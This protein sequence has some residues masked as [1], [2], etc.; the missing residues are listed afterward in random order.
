M[1]NTHNV[2]ELL[3]NLISDRLNFN[4]SAENTDRDHEVAE[5]LFDNVQS[6]LV[7][8][9]YCYE[10]D[11]TLDFHGDEQSDSGETG[12]ENGTDGIDSDDQSADDNHAD[13]KDYEYVYEKDEFPPNQFS[14]EY[15]QRVVE[16]YDEI[17]PSNGKRKHSFS[18][19]QQRFKR[20]KDKSYIRRFRTYIEREGTKRQKL[21]EIDAFVFESFNQT[22][23]QSLSVHDIDLKRWA[24]SKARELGDV[25]FATSDHWIKSF[26]HRHGIVSRKITKLTTTRDK[27][28]EKTISKTVDDFLNYSQSIIS[29][30]S[31]DRVFNT[32][33]SGLQL[34]VFSNRTMS[35]KGEKMTVA[36]VRSTN[37]TTHSYTVQPMI[38]MSGTVVGPLFLCLK[39]E[40]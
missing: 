31:S 1:I 36:A 14:L 29:K 13:D 37:N 8:T 30:Y 5:I 11:V 18:S 9:S 21:D 35:Y 24:L 23:K 33:Q 20:V 7:S 27:D 38:T 17:N 28:S 15:M 16:H 3:A 34:E 4:E 19:L 22:R 32:D 39:E 26:K 25:S 12:A 6:I 40:T 10:N 2:V